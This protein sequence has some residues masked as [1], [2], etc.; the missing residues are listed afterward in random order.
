MEESYWRLEDGLWYYYADIFSTRYKL[1]FE[2]KSVIEQYNY[3]GDWEDGNSVSFILFPPNLEEVKLCVEDEWKNNKLEEFSWMDSV[4]ADIAE[5]ENK[6]LKIRDSWK[7]KLKGLINIKKLWKELNEEME[8]WDVEGIVEIE[9]TGKSERGYPNSI[10]AKIKGENK[11]TYTDYRGEGIFVWQQ[12]GYNGDDYSG[13]CLY[14]LK[15]GKHLKI[16]YNC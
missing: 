3:M 13:W 4:W 12:T 9:L 11:Y 7:K 8:G 16:S 2:N 1:D 14:P 10:C 5:E 6:R 15:D